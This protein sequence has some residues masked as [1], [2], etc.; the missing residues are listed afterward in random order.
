MF[1][2]LPKNKVNN[3][4]GTM[5][6]L[7]NVKNL[8]SHKTATYSAVDEKVKGPLV[9]LAYANTEIIVLGTAH[10]SRESVN[11]VHHL[12]DA[13]DP[14]IICVEL[15]KP[16]YA[17]LKNRDRWKNLDI[18]DVIKTGKLY[19]LMS[20]VILSAFQKKMGEGT[21]VKPGE[22]MMAAIELAKDR[23]LKLI[24]RDIQITLKRAWQSMGY[25]TKIFLFSE[26][27][28]GLFVKADFDEIQIE[29]LKRK[30]SLDDI[31]SNLP[32]RFNKIKNIIITERDRFLAENIKRAAENNFSARRI[33]AV[34]GAGHLPGIK[35]YFH[36]RVDLRELEVVKKKSK[37][38]GVIKF[39]LPILIFMGVMYY[40]SDSRADK[41]LE[42]IIAWCIIKSASSAL[43]TLVL[44]AHPLAIL[45]AMVTAPIS[46]FNPVLKP[47]WVAALIEAKFRKPQV[48]DFE[49]IAS[50]SDSI[51]KMMK[52]RVIRIFA[53]F[54]LPQLGS[55]LGTFAFFAWY[56][57][58]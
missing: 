49:S 57:T 53:V 9:R 37:A 41:V 40:F 34:V 5:Q 33:V 32:F 39:F 35:K 48:V 10:I 46:N 22:E 30:D 15:C 6:N 17:A 43:F 21:G 50:D 47:G 45:A 44:L 29:E 4:R 12:V 20:S 27:L 11:D 16:R 13:F 28:T 56:I 38:L 7:K 14:D 58:G 23:Q 19:L 3:D 31:F 18:I 24:D 55:S 54:M 25:F 42:S 26:L 52:N 1:W 36:Q 51:F 8:I 2:P